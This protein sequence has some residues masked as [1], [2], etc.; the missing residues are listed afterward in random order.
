MQ[1][2]IKP[3]L[4]TLLA[5]LWGCASNS[6]LNRAPTLNKDN[7]TKIGNNVY[8]LNM[9]NPTTNSATKISLIGYSKRNPE[10]SSGV[11]SIRPTA[12]DSKVRVESFMSPKAREA[13]AE[14]H[15]YLHPI[16][17]NKTTPDAEG[18]S[19]AS[20][21]VIQLDP[22]P[23]KGSAAT[24]PIGLFLYYLTIVILMLAF[25]VGYGCYKKCKSETKSVNPFSDK[26]KK[27]YLGESI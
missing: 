13:A 27:E 4:L 9:K 3:L 21:N 19:P 20:L 1:D 23:S 11:A 5:L 24:K 12:P 7:L 6:G 17:V 8:S 25:Y 26:D 22:S 14:R 2:L 18:E 10:P 15:D 16:A